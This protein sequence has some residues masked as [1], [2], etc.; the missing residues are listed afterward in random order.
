MIKIR[1]II[2][3]VTITIIKIRITIT[4]SIPISTIDQLDDKLDVPRLYIF[5]AQLH[6]GLHRQCKR[7]DKSFCIVNLN[8]SEKKMHFVQFRSF[9]CL[10]YIVFVYG[11]PPVRKGL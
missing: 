2:I 3:L 5:F 11:T 1:I 8:M 4:I 7:K 6:K 9:C 10:V